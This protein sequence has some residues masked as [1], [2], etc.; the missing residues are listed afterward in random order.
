MVVDCGQSLFSSKIHG[1]KR[2]EERNIPVC[3]PVSQV[4]PRAASS[5]GV[6]RR[7]LVYRNFNERTQ[8]LCFTILLR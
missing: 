7:A 5:A 6:G 3:V 8:E 2:N 1:E 4:K